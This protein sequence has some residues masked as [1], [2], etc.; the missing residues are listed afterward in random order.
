MGKSWDCQR[1]LLNLDYSLGRMDNWLKL[2]GGEGDHLVCT[3][4][5][6]QGSQ[7]WGEEGGLGVHG[8]GGGHVE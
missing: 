6:E 5:G 2:D 7:G 8:E 3:G 4:V 1:K